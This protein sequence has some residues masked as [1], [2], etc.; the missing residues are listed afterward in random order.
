MKFVQIV[1]NS[2]GCVI[3]LMWANSVRKCAAS[4]SIGN[5]RYTFCWFISSFLPFCEGLQGDPADHPLILCKI[6]IA[7]LDEL[8]ELGAFLFRIFGSIECLCL[9]YLRYLLA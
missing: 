3:P 6:G 8:L 7:F 2:S 9:E 1:S 5:V 4:F